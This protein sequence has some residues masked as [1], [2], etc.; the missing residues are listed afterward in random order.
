M[1]YAA[2]VAYL[3]SSGLLPVRGGCLDSAGVPVEHGLKGLGAGDPQADRQLCGVGTADQ[4]REELVV[5]FVGLVDVLE[6]A[7]ETAEFSECRALLQEAGE[8]VREQQRPHGGVGVR[9]ERQRVQAEGA[10]GCQR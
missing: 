9:D 5:E 1:T 7:A 10:S 3:S 4:D 2:A 8:A 6:V